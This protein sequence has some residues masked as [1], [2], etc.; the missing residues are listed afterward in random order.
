MGI[1]TGKRM[2]TTGIVGVTSGLYR[3]YRVCIHIY[4]YI[5]IYR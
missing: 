4:T 5:Y 2:E 1:I 3:E